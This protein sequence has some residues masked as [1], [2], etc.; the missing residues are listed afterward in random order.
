MISC[1]YDAAEVYHVKTV[2]AAKPHKCCECHGAI[3]VGEPHEL[4]KGLWSGDWSSFRTCPD[5]VHLRCQL[6]QTFGEGD[7]GWLHE[8]MRE[9]LES[10]Q[11]QEPVKAEQFV[12]MFNACTTLRGAAPIQPRDKE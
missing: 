6:T 7:C 8:G 1:D 9:Q 12:A 5:C 10:L 11:Y 3:R 2:R 4:A